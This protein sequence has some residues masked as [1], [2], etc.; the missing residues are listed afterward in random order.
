MV[1][2]DVQLAR[3]GTE[4][5]RDADL[6]GSEP[7]ALTGAP[8]APCESRLRLLRPAQSAARPIGSISS[9]SFCARSVA[10]SPRAGRRGSDPARRHRAASRR[11]SSRARRSDAA[12][13]PVFTAYSP[14][15]RP[16][17]QSRKNDVS[18][19]PS[20][21][22]AAAA[23]RRLAAELAR[24]RRTTSAPRVVARAFVRARQRAKHAAAR[25]GSSSSAAAS[26]SSLRERRLAFL[27]ASS[28]SPT[29]RSRLASCAWT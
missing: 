25:H 19:G 20:S 29:S 15:L 17:H 11:A 23:A 3:D 7:R 14:N 2:V 24:T 27:L 8:F 6:A 4:W 26:R 21:R 22:V 1:E 5:N 18:R 28:S 12:P 10:A 9:Q 16:A 13:R